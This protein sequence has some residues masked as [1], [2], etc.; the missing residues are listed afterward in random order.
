M[1]IRTKNHDLPKAR[2]SGKT[3][4]FNFPKVSKIT[5]ISCLELSTATSSYLDFYGFRKRER[6]R[7]REKQRD[8]GRD[9]EIERELIPQTE[10]CL[11][12]IFCIPTVA[13]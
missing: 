1:K 9:R 6:E 7:N 11:F 5:K 10:V 13:P 3:T 8:R 2:V 4:N 12:W